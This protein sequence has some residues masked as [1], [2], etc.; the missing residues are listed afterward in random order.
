MSEPPRCITAP[1]RAGVFYG[2]W[3]LLQSLANAG[4]AEAGVVTDEPQVALRT[5]H[6]D[7]ARKYFTRRD[8][9]AASGVRQPRVDP[10]GVAT[11]MD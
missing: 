8:P 1:T 6:L 9:R 10:G 3:T 11:L 5:L 2:T 7:A 4:G